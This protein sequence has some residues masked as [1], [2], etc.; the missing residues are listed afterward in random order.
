MTPN[1]QENMQVHLLTQ[2]VTETAICILAI[3]RKLEL[4]FRIS[5]IGI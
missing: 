2:A 4:V 3:R 5:Y 1:L